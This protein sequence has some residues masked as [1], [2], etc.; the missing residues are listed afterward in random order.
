MHCTEEGPLSAKVHYSSNKMKIL[1]H[2]LAPT[3]DGTP[4]QPRQRSDHQVREDGNQQ[5]ALPRLHPRLES[6]LGLIANF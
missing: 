4:R 2:P 1:M 3:A 6:D 5:D